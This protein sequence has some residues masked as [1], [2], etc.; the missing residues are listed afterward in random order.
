MILQFRL[1]IRQN[2]HRPS[3]SLDVVAKEDNRTNL[4]YVEA[5]L[6]RKETVEAP[7]TTAPPVEADP[8]TPLHTEKASYFTILSRIATFLGVN[9]Y[10]R[11]RVVQDKE[12]FSF[13]VVSHSKESHT[14]L[15]EYLE[16]FPLISSKYLDYMD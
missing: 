6:G 5:D 2:Y 14:K 8:L 4:D 1:E 10:S 7:V 16:R 3:S 15:M 13:I 12:Y 11:S 9:I